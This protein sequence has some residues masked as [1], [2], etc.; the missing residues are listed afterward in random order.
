MMNI[1]AMIF[2]LLNGQVISFQNTLPVND[3]GTVL[4]PVRGVFQAMGASVDYNPVT[5]DVVAEKGDTKIEMAVGRMHAW[6]NE[7]LVELPQPVRLQDGHVLIPARFIAE[8]FGAK[9]LWDKAKSRVLISTSE[10]DG[11]AVP[12]TPVAS[13]PFEISFNSD[14]ANYAK[15]EKVM[16]TLIARN[17]SDEDQTLNFR[18]G[19]S[20][21]ISITPLAQNETIWR[22]D[23]SFG[24]FFT[25]A[26]R[27][28]V[29]KP[30]QSMSLSAEWDQTDNSG[31]PMPRG[32]YSVS[33][34]ITT[35]DEIEAP[36]I[37]VTL[38]E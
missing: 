37:R 14:K 5:R 38:S 29:L 30:N 13:A 2:V 6:V 4:V 16:F 24:R 11:E 1:V 23:W 12:S 9:V 32:E 26:E 35:N 18:S 20:F 27:T 10:S 28:K 34:K 19:Q 3:G 15:G 7:E 22:W 17:A 25:E 36:R 8:A 21:D 33:A 31:K